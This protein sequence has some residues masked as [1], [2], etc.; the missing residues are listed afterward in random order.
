MRL[1]WLVPALALCVSTFS[2]GGASSHHSACCGSHKGWKRS[3]TSS[4]GGPSAPGC[5]KCAP[6]KGI[7]PSVGAMH[8]AMHQTGARHGRNDGA[9][10]HGAS[11]AC[12]SGDTRLN[13]Q[14]QGTPDPRAKG[15]VESKQCGR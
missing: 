8:D 11:T 9:V 7:K 14:G 12:G 6:S 3:R 15:P 13:T 1:L 5:T 10:E 2:E 4:N